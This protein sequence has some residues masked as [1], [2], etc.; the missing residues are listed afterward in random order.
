MTIQTKKGIEKFKEYVEKFNK[1]NKAPSS[2]SYYIF[3]DSVK[4]IFVS[5]KDYNKIKRAIKR[6]L[7]NEKKLRENALKPENI[8]MYKSEEDKEFFDFI[9]KASEKDF[10]T[11]VKFTEADRF[12]EKEMKAFEKLPVTRELLKKGIK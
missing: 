8:F 5:I 1:V 9:D 11:L 6:H 3:K 12:N 7:E 4:S 10:F 2:E